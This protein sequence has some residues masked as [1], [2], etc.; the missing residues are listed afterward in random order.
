MGLMQLLGSFVAGAAGWF[1]LEFVGRPVRRFF[2]LRGEVLRQMAVFANVSARWKEVRDSVGAISGER[3][4]MGL[5]AVEN[6]RL[7]EAQR[8]L[9]DLASQMRAFTQNEW[10]AARIVRWLRFDPLKASAGL[11]GLSNVLDTHG[12][13]RAFQTKTVEDALRI[14]RV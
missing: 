8:L 2:D 3:E 4:D 11:F 14:A 12:G 10:L 6:Q 13:S 5:S 7:E 9:R 1:A